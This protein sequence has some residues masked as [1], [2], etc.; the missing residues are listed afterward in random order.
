MF[1]VFFYGRFSPLHGIEHI[2]RAAALLE[3][4][5]NPVRFVLVGAGQTYQTMRDLAERFGVSTVE[6]VGAV[7]YSI[8]P[9]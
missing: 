9:P 2:I 8:W 6:F 1:T 4:R 3:A 7:P 5:R